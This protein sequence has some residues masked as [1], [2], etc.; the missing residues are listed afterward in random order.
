MA[1]R[2]IDCKRVVLYFD[3]SLSDRIYHV[4]E[5]SARSSP[6]LQQRCCKADLQLRLRCLCH[7]CQ[8]GGEVPQ[9]RKTSAAGDR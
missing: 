5:R 6:S 9:M 8:G 1:Y 3:K 2:S 4:K 7:T